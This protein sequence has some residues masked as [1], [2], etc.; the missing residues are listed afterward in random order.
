MLKSKEQQEE[1]RD[2]RKWIDEMA[3]I[4]EGQLKWVTLKN[5]I[6][7][8]RS[9]PGNNLIKHNKTITRMGN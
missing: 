8:Q 2:K 5:C 4:V 6:I 7:S 1:I 3:S 9:Y